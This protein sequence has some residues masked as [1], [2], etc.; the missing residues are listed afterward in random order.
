MIKHL[1]FALIT[2]FSL[3]SQEI[4][5]VTWSYEVEKLSSLKYKITFDAQIIDSPDSIFYFFYKLQR[6]TG[7]GASCNGANTYFWHQG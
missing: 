6:D 7:A 5:P 1:F 3:N 4:E 2:I